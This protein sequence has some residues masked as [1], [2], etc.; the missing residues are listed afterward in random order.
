MFISLKNLGKRAFVVLVLFVLCA[1]LPAA[2]SASA[3][4]GNSSGEWMKEFS[5][6]DGSVAAVWQMSD[7]DIVAA[8][9][10]ENGSEIFGLGPDGNISWKKDIGGGE[11]SSAVFVQESPLG[12]LYLFT[13][14]EELVKTDDS[15]NVEWTYRQPY[16]VISSIE[17][18]DN[19]NVLM[20]GDYLQSFL[21]MISPEGNET[22]NKTLDTPDGGGQY[23]L[24][25]VQQM[26]D[27]EFVVAGY[28]NP[29]MYTEN[30]RGF[31]MKIN[32]EGNVSWAKQY[33]YKDSAMITTVAPL[34]DGGLAAG[35]NKITE[36]AS[37][38]NTEIVPYIL[39]TDSGGY[40][41]TMF[42]V[43]GVEVVYYVTE[44]PDKGFYMLGTEEN[45]L[46][47]SDEYEYK[48]LKT[49]NAGSLE[50]SKSF[51]ETR[52]NSLQQTLNGEILMA[53]SDTGSGNGVIIK[54]MP[55]DLEKETNSSKSPGFG[56][57]IAVLG[58]VCAA[59]I[60]LKK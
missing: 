39:I 4:S 33:K 24:S 58:A 48:L 35:L 27:G 29:I 38:N 52:I 34:E 47:G 32:E 54:I 60:R 12:G 14:D 22:W 30:Y 46:A 50:V 21:I 51:G 11:N 16:G 26:S 9:S 43:P 7:G 13:S 55:G 56:Y 10:G 53:G 20:A 23:R 8:G 44:A 57:V 25:S 17:V 41:K 15:G 18:A 31:M 37:D 42:N 36:G 2:V 59:A 1:V 3:D 6:E 49:D 45:T 5:L 28:I 19:G 40:Q